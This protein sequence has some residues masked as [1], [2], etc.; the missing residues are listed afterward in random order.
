MGASSGAIGGILFGG[1]SEGDKK[2]RGRGKRN[3]QSDKRKRR[4]KKKNVRQFSLKM[5]TKTK[6]INKWFENEGRIKIL[7]GKNIFNYKGGDWEKI[8][9]ER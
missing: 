5:G 7:R 9:K 3:D 1:W 8:K 4:E 2:K 6:K